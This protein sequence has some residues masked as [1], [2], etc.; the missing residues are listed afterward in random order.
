M[1]NG[2]ALASTMSCRHGGGTDWSRDCRKDDCAMTVMAGASAQLTRQDGRVPATAICHPDTRATIH[3]RNARTVQ[4]LGLEIA[5]KIHQ[6]RK[7]GG[8]T[9]LRHTEGSPRPCDLS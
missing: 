5:A 8:R 1:K 7:L 4:G 2:I 9:L 6:R 3:K